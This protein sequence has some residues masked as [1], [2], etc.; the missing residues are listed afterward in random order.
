MSRKIA[1][2]LTGPG[3]RGGT[4]ESESLQLTDWY[5]NNGKMIGGANERE[6]MNRVHGYHRILR[7]MVSSFHLDHKYAT[8][9][10]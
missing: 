8:W 3:G 2:R 10:A 6:S 9:A 7:I 1:T 4:S 5:E